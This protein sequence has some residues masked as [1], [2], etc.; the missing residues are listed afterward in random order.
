MS[1]RGLRRVDGASAEL[2]AGYSQ[3]AG[4]AAA[5]RTVAA[6]EAAAARGGESGDG[7]LGNG[8]GKSLPATSL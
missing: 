8:Q 2:L 1:T 3:T 6:E 7:P 5:V 4:G